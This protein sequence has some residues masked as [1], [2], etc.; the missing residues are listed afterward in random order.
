[1]DLILLL[2]LSFLKGTEEKL[3]IVI[4]G[5]HI[6]TVKH[7]G[8]YDGILGV[9]AAIEVG[10]VIKENNLKHRRGYQVVVFT[11]EEGS[12]FS[13]NLLGSKA[14]AGKIEFEDIKDL[15]DNMGISMVDMIEKLG[16]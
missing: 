12:N 2:L 1:M 14:I 6:D 16:V 13:V 10:R 3:P 15:K 4:S 7:G 9:V 8:N 11:E 5:S